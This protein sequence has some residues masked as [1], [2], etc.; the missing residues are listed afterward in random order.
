[1]FSLSVQAHYGL[2]KNDVAEDGQGIY[3]RDDLSKATSEK[4]CC[5]NIFKNV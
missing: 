1:M 4:H 2:L 5:W 3:A